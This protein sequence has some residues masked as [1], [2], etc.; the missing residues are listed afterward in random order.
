LGQSAGLV[1]D[2]A[3]GGAAFAFPGAVAAFVAAAV[4]VDPTP[5]VTS[6]REATE[7][8]LAASFLAV[9][10]VLCYA[11]VTQVAQRR[12]SPPLALGTG[13]GALAVTAAAFGAPGATLADAWVGGLLLVSAVLLV[14]APS[15][16]A[17]RRADRLLDGS[18]IAAAAVTAAL[19]GTLARV[20]GL[21]GDGAELAA[22][23]FLIL[24]VAAGIRAMPADWRRGPVLGIALTGG[25]VALI[26]GWTAL[27][28]GLRVLATPGRLWEANLADW[29]VGGAGNG[30]QAPVALVLL[31]G[32]AAIALPRPWAYD[33][34]GVCVGLATIGAPVALGLPWWSPIVVGGAVATVYGVTAVVAADP[35]AGLA[36]A[37]V[38]AA[39]AV[40]AVGASLVR[41]WTTAV[42]LGVVALIGFVVATLARAVGTLSGPAEEAESWTL[43]P[44]TAQIG[45]L[46]A[47]GALFALAGSLAALA[48]SLGW[49]AEVVVLANLGAASLGVAVVALVRRH[50]PQYLP[51]ATI[52]IVAGAPPRP[53]CSAYSPNWSGRSPRRQPRCVS[54]SAA[55]RSCSAERCGGSPNRPGPAAGRSAPP[56][57]R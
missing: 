34:A 50:V 18:D 23:A 8:V 35:R 29:P 24:V 45:G 48:A 44:Q 13:L 56:S 14:L 27:S 4:P 39:V 51:Y 15:I 16:D 52:G 1:A 55:G 53:S 26:A 54:R 42:A 37:T 36:R 31:A 38:A 5:T 9:C 28:G 40:H 46:A 17:G 33:V 43:S 49:S 12:I 25:V 41:P 19:V 21:L 6:V 30:W 3:A 32:A 20:A 47:G 2:W 7:P 10:A 57:G 11:A 22:A